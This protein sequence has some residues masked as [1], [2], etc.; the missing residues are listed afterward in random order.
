MGRRSPTVR[1]TDEF[2]SISHRVAEANVVTGQG[3]TLHIHITSLPSEK[4]EHRDQR[5]RCE[6]RW[7]LSCDDVSDRAMTSAR[8]GARRSNKASNAPSNHSQAA[9]NDR[10]LSSCAAEL[11]SL[12]L[13]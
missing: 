11:H 6:Q 12:A 1:D 13:I 9:P 7:V 3:R 4:T 2:L 8:L 10:H 5:H